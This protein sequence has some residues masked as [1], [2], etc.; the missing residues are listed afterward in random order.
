MTTTFESAVMGDDVWDIQH[1]W[2]TIYAVNPNDDFPI[3]VT[4]DNFDESYRYSGQAWAWIGSRTLSQTLFW[5]R[6]VIEAPVKPTPDLEVDTKVLVWNNPNIKNRRHFSHFKHG[7]IYTFDD[8]STSFTN[9]DGESV[10]GWRN[11]ELPK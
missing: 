8:G 3:K 7:R 5:D 1:G 9:P 10:T 11:W 2:G 6:V 4:F